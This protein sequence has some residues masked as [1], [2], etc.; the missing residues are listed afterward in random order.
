MCLCKVYQQVKQRGGGG[1]PSVEPLPLQ[2]A[3][4][5]DARSGA[6]GC[7]WVVRRVCRVD[8]GGVLNV[9]SILSGHT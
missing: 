2:A 1:G 6:V 3:V 8:G 7:V 9:T 5:M 4:Q